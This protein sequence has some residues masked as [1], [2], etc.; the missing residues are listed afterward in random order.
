MLAIALKRFTDDVL[1]E[2]LQVT[3][4]N[5]LNGLSGR[6]ALLRRLGTTLEESPSVFTHANLSRP[7]YMLGI[8]IVTSANLRLPSIPSKYLYSR[9]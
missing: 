3:E 5:P 2:G 7:G 6:S 4:S 9:R 8:I 1:A